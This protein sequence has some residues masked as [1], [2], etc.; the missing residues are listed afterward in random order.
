MLIQLLIPNSWGL[1]EW[2]Y[3]LAGLVI[4]WY[5]YRSFRMVYH[6]SAIRTITKMMG[7]ALAYLFAFSICITAVALITALIAV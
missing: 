4:I 2:M 7:I 3:G 1:T 6:R 5:T